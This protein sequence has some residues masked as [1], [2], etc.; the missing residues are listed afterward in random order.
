MKQKLLACDVDGTLIQSHEQ[1]ISQED[2]NAI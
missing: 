2:L 1:F